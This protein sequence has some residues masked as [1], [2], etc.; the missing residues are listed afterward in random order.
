MLA[1]AIVRQWHE[2]LV[3]AL[4]QIDGIDLGITWGKKKYTWRE[5]AKETNSSLVDTISGEI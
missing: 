5:L 3:D 2:N 1:L 4:L